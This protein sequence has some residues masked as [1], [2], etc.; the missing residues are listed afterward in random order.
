[1]NWRRRK[2]RAQP[3]DGRPAPQGA[4]G[5]QPMTNGTNGGAGSWA[6]PG[7]FAPEFPTVLGDPGDELA[8]VVWARDRSRRRNRRVPRIRCRTRRLRRFRRARALPSRVPGPWPTR[9]RVQVP[10]PPQDRRPR[11]DPVPERAARHATA[12]AGLGEAAPQ[13]RGRHALPARALTQSSPIAPSSRASASSGD[14]EHPT[15]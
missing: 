15:D 7:L 3:A 11:P 2:T 4:T 6:L 14:R 1:M 8:D 13:R 12:R 5:L 9:R 10:H